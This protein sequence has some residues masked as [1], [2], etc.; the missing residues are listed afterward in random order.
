MFLPDYPVVNHY[1]PVVGGYPGEELVPLEEIR[2][3]QK[4]DNVIKRLTANITHERDRDCYRGQLVQFMRYIPRLGVDGDQLNYQVGVEKLSP[5]VSQAFVIDWAIYLNHSY[6]H[7][8]REK[9]IDLLQ[10]HC[11]HPSLSKIANDVTSS[12]EHCQVAKVGGHFSGTPA[13]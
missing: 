4:S 9:L 6:G 5:V 8:G 7:P 13:A 11:W 2:K 12:C 3:D 10:K 1:I